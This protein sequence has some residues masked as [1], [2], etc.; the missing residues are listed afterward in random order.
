MRPQLLL[1]TAVVLFWGAS[2]FLLVSSHRRSSS[3]STAAAGVSTARHAVVG[4]DGVALPSADAVHRIWGSLWGDACMVLHDACLDEG[5]FVTFGDSPYAAASPARLWGP[6]NATT[7]T[8]TTGSSSSKQPPWLKQVKLGNNHLDF[9]GFGDVAGIVQYPPP[10]I[11][12]GHAANEEAAD[13]QPS[14]RT[15]SPCA[16]PVVLYLNFVYAFGDWWLRSMP[17]FMHARA[18]GAWDTRATLVIATGGQRLARWQKLVL[19]TL[20]EQPIV[21]LSA[22]SSRALAA[23]G[24]QQQPERQHRH[25]LAAAARRRLQ[26]QPSLTAYGRCFELVAVCSVPGARTF[27]LQQPGGARASSTNSSSH[28]PRETWAG[29]QHVKQYYQ[30]RFGQHSPLPRGFERLKQ[31]RAFRVVFAV[32]GLPAAA[33]APGGA[34]GREWRDWSEAELAASTRQLLNL[35]QLL[36]WCNAWKPTAAAGSA[37]LGDVS[38]GD[39]AGG[40]RRYERA[41]CV[42]HEFGQ[43]GRVEAAA[44]TQ[45]RRQGSALAAD[46]ELDPTALLTDLAVLEQAGA[47]AGGPRARQ[48]A[49]SELSWVW[50]HQRICSGCH[51]RLT[52]ARRC[53]ACLQTSWWACMVHSCSTRC[54][55]R[56]T[57]RWWK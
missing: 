26:E 18:A 16:R 47:A 28:V 10:I 38:A 34:S 43:H 57:R 37:A 17:A 13:M 36:A 41:A 15:F 20:G 3:S 1:L 25:A 40:S 42:A 22:A 27:S 52:A 23:P 49:Q 5:T 19:Q 24:Q 31:R 4:C 9:R 46:P 45:Q 56:L 55:C 50:C 11:R 48:Q 39:T 7:A 33:A 8:S 54:S 51:L 30:E 12:P 21:T 6:G 29:A 14:T 2:S 53:P 35:P 44:A 32:R